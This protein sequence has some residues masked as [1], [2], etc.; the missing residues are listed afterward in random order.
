MSPLTMA[1]FAIGM[2]AG[3]FGCGVLAMVIYP[4]KRPPYGLGARRDSRR[5][6]AT[7][8]EA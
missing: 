3:G 6:Q 8:E 2:F 1:I 4:P 7:E 5:V